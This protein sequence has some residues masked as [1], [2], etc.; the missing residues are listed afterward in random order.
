MNFIDEKIKT[1]MDGLY[2]P[3]SEEMGILREKAEENHIPII[4]KDTEGFLLSIL[5]AGR[6]MRIL[7]I[8][9]AVGYSA[10]LFAIAEPHCRVDTIERNPEM[11]KEAVKNIEKLGLSDR[12]RVHFGEATNV[13]EELLKGLDSDEIELEPEEE[14]IAELLGDPSMLRLYDM[15]FIDAGKSHYREFWDAAMGLVRPGSIIICDN[16]LMKGKTVS[17]EYD[18][19]GKHKTNIRKMREFVE[20]LSTN[21]LVDTTFLPIGDG[22]SISVVRE[23]WDTDTIDEPEFYPIN[24]N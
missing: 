1:Y 14:I 24:L 5:K 4:L 21:D 16:V 20:F 18:P 6:M 10:S 19:D 9:T 2:K 12:I 13:M 8:G 23:I 22:I 17:D 11:F 3:V 15:V 7:E